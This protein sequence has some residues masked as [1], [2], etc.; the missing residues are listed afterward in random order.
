ML[1]ELA[2]RAQELGGASEKRATTSISL[3]AEI[4]GAVKTAAG[5]DR[6]RPFGTISPAAALAKSDS[7]R[8]SRDEAWQAVA[9]SAACSA[10]AAGQS[11]RQVAPVC[12]LPGRGRR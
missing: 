7:E 3:A 8:M 11:W 1:R 2:H 9:V 10:R 5:R 12:S 6:G 4:V